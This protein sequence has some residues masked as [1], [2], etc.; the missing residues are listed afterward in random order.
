M[1]KSLILLTC[2]GLSAFRTL[3]SVS[4]HDIYF[5]LKAGQCCFELL[6][7]LAALNKSK[8]RATSAKLSQHIGSQSSELSFDSLNVY[9]LDH[10]SLFRES[11]M[12]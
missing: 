5:L 4:L 11:L 1:Q 8:P 12:K 10:I 7:S 2:H 9:F 3:K 6:A